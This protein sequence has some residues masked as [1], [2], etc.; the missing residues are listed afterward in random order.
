MRP[1]RKLGETVDVGT[2]CGAAALVRMGQLK[3]SFRSGFVKNEPGDMRSFRHN[4]VMRFIMREV[5]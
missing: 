5:L 4:E 1:H 2:F 3:H